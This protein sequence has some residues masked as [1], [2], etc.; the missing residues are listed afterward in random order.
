MMNF[1]S[2]NLIVI[3]IIY[4]V[5]PLADLFF[6]LNGILI[7]LLITVWM[8]TVIFHELG[9]CFIAKCRGMRIAFI[10]GLLGMYMN[11]RYFFKIPMYFSFG[12]MLAYKPLRKGHI[13]KHDIIWL[14]SGGFIFNLISVLVLLLIDQ[15]FSLD[16]YILNFAI[17]MN[18]IIGVVTGL[19]PFAA[20]GKSIWN[21][22]RGKNDELKFYDSMNYIYDSEVSSTRILEELDRDRDIIS[23]YASNIAWVERHVDSNEITQVYQTELHDSETL[24]YKLIK[25]FQLL[26]KAADG[27]Q[28]DDKEVEIFNEVNT[29]LYVVFGQ[30]YQYFKT[31]DETILDNL[32]RKRIWLPSQRENKLLINAI[33]R[34]I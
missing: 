14:N 5:L 4:L 17:R 8:A 20:D 11:G 33:Q 21:L 7:A 28:I 29:S 18:I 22:L 23:T 19:N 27:H 32:L 10:S 31:G 13:T 25:A 16:S 3:L 6:D 2:S 26:Y 1:F 12:A 34:I 15:L 9:H 30:V 24:N